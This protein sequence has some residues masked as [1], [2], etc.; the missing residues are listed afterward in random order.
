M[1]PIDVEEERDDV[2]ALPK[3]VED[4]FADQRRYWRGLREDG[5]IDLAGTA[6][7]IG[8]HIEGPSRRQP[9]SKRW[10]GQC[11]DGGSDSDSKEQG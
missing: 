8:R 6:E 10:P 3:W 11:T 5:I 1:R 9:A 2:P 4:Y 7:I